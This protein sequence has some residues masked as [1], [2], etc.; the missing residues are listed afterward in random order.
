[1]FALVDQIAAQRRRA[2]ADLSNIADTEARR[3]AAIDLCVDTGGSFVTAAEDGGAFAEIDLLGVYHIGEDD[4][5]CVAN[6]I[7]AASRCAAQPITPQ[8]ETRAT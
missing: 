1:M 3:R 5:E 6:W 7:K 8:A 4:E 2:A